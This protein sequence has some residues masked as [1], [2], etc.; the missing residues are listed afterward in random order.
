MEGCN[1]EEQ[2]IQEV[3]TD[4]TMVH[5]VRRKASLGTI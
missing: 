2:S 4:V 5:Q 1:A 3:D